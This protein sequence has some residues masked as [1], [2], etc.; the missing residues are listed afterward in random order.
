MNWDWFHG[1]VD[2]GPSVLKMLSLEAMLVCS[3]RGTEVLYCVPLLGG[4]GPR[5]YSSDLNSKYDKRRGIQWWRMDP[6]MQQRVVHR[7]HLRSGLHH[8]SMCLMVTIS[9]AYQ[10]RAG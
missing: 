1:S 4:R 5:H 10:Q 6:Q 8:V 2:D 3:T 7:H 9:K